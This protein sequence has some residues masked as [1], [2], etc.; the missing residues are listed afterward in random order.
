M[1]A[2]VLNCK[3]LSHATWILVCVFADVLKL[4]DNKTAA[5]ARMSFGF[6]LNHWKSSK[7]GRW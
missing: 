6:A 1:L 7:K 2:I 5:T 3:S 4:L